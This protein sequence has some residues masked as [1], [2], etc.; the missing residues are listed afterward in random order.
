MRREPLPAGRKSW[1]LP[2]GRGAAAV[3]FA[4]ADGRTIA[5]C[6][7]RED[8]RSRDVPG[9]ALRALP[10]RL[11]RRHVAAALSAAAELPEVAL[12]DAL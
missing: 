8:V 3:S 5:G 12:A 2:G 9:L 11:E 4:S 10:T 1:R 6:L 7:A